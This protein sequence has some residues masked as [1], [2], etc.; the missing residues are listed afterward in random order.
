MVIKSHVCRRLTFDD[1]Q[2]VGEAATGTGD[3]SPPQMGDQHVNIEEETR[4]HLEAAKQRWN[5]DFQNEVPLNGRWQW[6]KVLGSEPTM[7]QGQA[8][9]EDEASEFDTNRPEQ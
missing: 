1:M 2:N 5:F 9:A 6:E 4:S 8:D 3:D 7:Q